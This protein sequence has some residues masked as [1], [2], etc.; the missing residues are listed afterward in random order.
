LGVSRRSLT[1][2]LKTCTKRARR[3]K[4]AYVKKEISG[5]NRKK[6]EEYGREHKDKIIHDF[7][8]YLYFIDE[9]YID[10]SSQAQGYILREEGT[11]EDTE[12][13]QERGEKTGVK[14]HIA[15]WVNWHEKAKKLVFYHDEE[16]RI[17]RPKRP[18]KSRTRKYESKEEFE[19]R[20][21]VWD[22][23]LP[24][25]VVV[26]L[27]GNSMTQKYYTERLLPVY[28][29]AVQQARLRRPDP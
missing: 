24:H 29:D 2:R 28:I 16:E 26:K 18:R 10:P 25:D 11:R 21:R 3:Y 9:V 14:L 1:S 5:P 27:K 13:I 8:Q 4:R 15:A 6:R 19:E 12:N 17:V 20:L 23:S 7:W 22:A